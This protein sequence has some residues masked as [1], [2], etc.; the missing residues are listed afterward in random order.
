MP[1]K[2]FMTGTDHR[3]CFGVVEGLDR[4]AFR[5][6]VA[7][8]VG[9]Q[10]I[11]MG[12]V[13]QVFEADR[14][15][16]VEAHCP[17]HM[18]GQA[19][20]RRQEGQA[21][22]MARIGGFGTAKPAPDIAIMLHYR[23]ATARVGMNAV[24]A[25]Y[26]LVRVEFGRDGHAIFTPQEERLRIDRAAYRRFADASRMGQREPCVAHDQIVR[27]PV[28]DRVHRHRATAACRWRGVLSVDGPVLDFKHG[29]ILMPQHC[30]M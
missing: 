2:N 26:A 25:G 20:F 23:I 10:E 3:D 13:D 6:L 17:D 12:Q 24:V 4:L 18:A 9:V 11:G 19:T 1:L 29:R 16:A 14:S 15:R 22:Q 30:G 21:G 5:F 27:H 28:V 8:D 7:R